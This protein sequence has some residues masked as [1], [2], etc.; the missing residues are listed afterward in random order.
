M[1]KDEEW[2]PWETR[3]P[4]LALPLKAVHPRKR[5]KDRDKTH[6]LPIR[7]EAISE[8]KAPSPIKPLA[9]LS[10]F[11]STFAA[12][13]AV[14]LKKRSHMLSLNSQALTPPQDIGPRSQSVTRGG[15][16]SNQQRIWTNSSPARVLIRTKHQAIS[17]FNISLHLG[18]EH[19]HMGQKVLAGPLMPQTR[20][21]SPVLEA[22]ERR[23]SRIL[24]KGH[25]HRF[26]QM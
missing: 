1:E 20:K 25:Q 7:T 5:P 11:N 26:S 3:F 9:V 19:F 13:P 23:I 15:N 8:T 22:L 10:Y 12:E 17:P 6:R 18:S 4:S 16:S 2:G 21:E 14:R 24:V